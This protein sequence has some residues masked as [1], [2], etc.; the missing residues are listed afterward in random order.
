M[1]FI[2]P[3]L[4]IIYFVF[5]GILLF[6]AYSIIRDQSGRVNRITAFM[7]FWAATGPI[8]LAFGTIAR[9]DTLAAAPFEESALYNLAYIWEL[10]FPAFLLFSWVFPIDRLSRFRFP[11]LRYIIFFPSVFHL[12]LVLI[13]NNPERIL[14]LLEDQSGEG[15]NSLLGWFISFFLKPILYLLKLTVLGFSLL[16]GRQKILFSA[17]N[18]IYVAMAVY[19]ILKG[20][21]QL[22]N[23]QL[24]KQSTVIIWGISIAIGLYSIAFLMPDIFSFD[25][26][27]GLK[28]SILVVALIIGG[29]SVGWSLIKHQFLD[30]SVIIRQ[31]LV[32][33]ISSG[34]LVGLYILFVDQGNRLITSIMGTKTTIVTI[35]FIVAALFLF[36][37]INSQLDNIIRRLFLR[38]R[39]DYRNLME[40]L[41]RQLISVFDP[42]Q[43]RNMVEKTLKSSILIDHIYFVLFDDKINEYA[44]FPSDNIPEKV[45]I[46]RGD[47]LLGGIG[48]LETPTMIDRLAV[49]RAGSI[50]ADELDKRRVQLILP[51][52]DA[53][54]LLGF[55]ALTEKVSGFR[56]N[57]EDVTMLRILSNQLITIL[58][59]ARL[60]ADSLEKQ[61]LDEEIA[62][63]RQ[64]QLDL[65]PKVYPQ[66]DIFQISACSIPS[67][68]IGGDFYDFIQKGDEALGIVIADASGKGMPAALLVAQ[69]QAMLRSEVGNNGHIKNI[70]SNINKYIVESTSAE[71][72]ATLFYGE[73]NKQRQELHYANA[74]HNYP[75]LIREDGAYELL[76]KGGILLG[77]FA[78]MEYQEGIVQLRKN[79]ILFLYTDGLSEA[80]NQADEEY[81][82]EKILK[83][84]TEHRHLDSNEIIDGILA[85]VRLFDP[86][87]PPR[88]DTT[89]IALKIRKGNG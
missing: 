34:I 32:Y 19:S 83:Y 86:T 31:S 72:F 54:H 3:V 43:I 5:A 27:A 9:L 85:E 66:T 42:V 50:L 69:I 74:G 39:T 59:N 65:L 84:L 8:F 67:R 61:R 11:K 4:T 15:V 48:Q 2:Q 36:Q 68:T 71:K 16:L 45:I 6:L 47:L 21:A 53:N 89:L 82:E 63:A 49:Y 88:D 29:G 18:L 70:L 17:I 64:I 52:K 87:D 23:Q 12:F 24:R 62:V 77:A 75:I 14:K 58:T 40:L 80:Q 78:G 25:I 81:G 33:T 46:P 10:F 26:P 76:S 79:D 41:S 28:T 20:R 56:Y 22:A 30:V 38:S 73:F 44:L 60:Y 1:E 57:A 37:P 55:L 35:A 7:L 51:L 13:F